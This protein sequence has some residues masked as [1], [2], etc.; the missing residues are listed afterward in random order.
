MVKNTACQD[1]ELKSKKL[2]IGQISYLNIWPFFYYL[3]REPFKF[4]IKYVKNHPSALNKLLFQD[5]LDLAPASS[6]EY[7]IHS[8]RY[9]LFPNLSISAKEAVQSVLLCSN[10]PLDSFKKKKNPIVYLSQASASSINLLKILW[11]FYWKLPEPKWTFVKPGETKNFPFLEIGDF[12]LNIY[13]KQKNNFYIYDLAHEWFKFTN[14]P[15]VFA[16]W[17]IN[18]NLF[19][20]KKELIYFLYE[21]LIKSK[22]LLKIEKKHLL[23]KTK[24]KFSFDLNVISNYWDLMDYNLDK[25]HKASLILFAHYLEKMKIIEGIP[26]LQ[27]I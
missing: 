26:T 12:A 22:H 5:E 25:E 10:L 3:K 14:L 7:L 1:I 6:F 17:I 4:S 20:I 2:K 13:Y 19:F 16:L 11:N 8:D 27:W 18:K 24:T 15:F 21:T 9:L 23:Q